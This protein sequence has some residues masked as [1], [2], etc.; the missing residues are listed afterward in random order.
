MSQLLKLPNRIRRQVMQISDKDYIIN[1]LNKRIGQC[2]KC[3]QCC[4]G[5]KFLDTETKLCKV[6]DDRPWLC[7][8]DFPLDKLDQKIWGVKNCGYNFE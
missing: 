7:H 8:K 4:K 6:Y 5:C 2:K 1:K 3:G